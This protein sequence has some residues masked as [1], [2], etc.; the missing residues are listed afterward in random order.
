MKVTLSKDRQKEMDAIQNALDNINQAQVSTFDK[1]DNVQSNL[2]NGKID[3][4]KN[5]IMHSGNTGAG[6]ETVDDD[7]MAD[8][9]LL[10]A[11]RYSTFLSALP[12]FHGVNMPEKKSVPVLGKA[13]LFGRNSEKT[14]SA[15]AHIE[16]TTAPTAEVEIVQGR[17]V[18]RIDVSRVVANYSKVDLENYIRQRLQESAIRTIE[19][20]IINSD[21]ETGAT[22]NVNKDDGAPAGTEYY[23]EQDHGLRELAING[24]YTE[25]VGTLDGDDFVSVAANLGM[26]MANPKDCMWLF[27]V[28]TY[29]KAHALDKF[30]KADERGDKSVLA[31]NLMTT[32]M[33]APAYINQDMGK[34][35]ADGKVSATGGNNTKGQ[36][37][38]V[39]RYAIQWGYG[40]P[41]EVMMYNFGAQGYQLEAWFDMG[42]A[43]YNTEAGETDPAVSWGINVTL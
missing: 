20:A 16:G 33:G 17:Y 34:T 38:L 36:F 30:I 23:L 40:Q 8:N 21:A 37:G 31:G 39:D 9:I 15:F 24:S 2:E 12:S 19:A 18:L 26:R 10:G 43:V 22:G 32:L 7:E 11:Q 25:S 41:L 35:E 29:W 4:D 28:D 13:P 6:A 42:F 14:S 5:T 1:L 3:L 27:N